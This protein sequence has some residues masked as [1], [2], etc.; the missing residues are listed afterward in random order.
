MIKDV[1]EKLILVTEMSFRITFGHI[2][3]LKKM[4]GEIHPNHCN[5]LFLSCF[6]RISYCLIHNENRFGLYLKFRPNH[7]RND[8]NLFFMMSK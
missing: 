1:Y 3:N 4:A 2:V 6:I 8:C 7:L 5:Q